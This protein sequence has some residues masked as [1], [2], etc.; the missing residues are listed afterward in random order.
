[1]ESLEQRVVLA[2]LAW[3]PLDEVSGT[4]A[5]DSSGNGHHGTVT[6][7]AWA[8]GQLDGAI[9]FNA[10]GNISVPS[11]ALA[12]VDQE[13][14]I[15]LWT[16]GGDTQPVSDSILYGVN[17][18][19]DRVFNVHLPFTNGRVY[20]D[21]GQD[22][23][24]DRINKVADPLVHRDSWHHWAFTKNVATGRMN[25]YL[26]G[27]LWHSG[28]G[29]TKSM[30][31]V[32]SF[33]LGAQTNGSESYDGLLDDVRI[34][35][36]EL[37]SAEVLGLFTSTTSPNTEEVLTTNRP[38]AVNDGGTVIITKAN[39]EA[40]DAEQSPS[41][42]TYTVTGIPANGTLHRSGTALVQYDTFT[43]DDLDN[44]R[45]TYGHNSGQSTTDSFTF[46]VNDG[47]GTATS[48]T[49]SLAVATVA[50]SLAELRALGTSV[51]NRLV[52]LSVTGGDPHPVT[53]VVTPGEYWI[54]GD[55]YADPTNSAPVF[56]ELSGTG[57][58]YDLAGTTI[59]LDTRK[60]DGFGRALGHDSGVDVVRV[61]GSG[62]VVKNLTV[63]GE[64]I[65]LDTDPNAQRYADWATQYI[66]L[67]GDDNTIDGVTVVTRGSR[68]D[69]YGL[70]DA[71]GKGSSGGVQPFI[72]HRKAS[73]FRVGEATNAVINNMHLDVNTFGHGFFVQ[74]STN[75]TL[76]N[77]TITGELFSSQG[78]LDRPEYQEY[79]HTFWGRP[80]PEDILISGNEGGVRM[81]TGASGLTVDNV[82]VTNMRTGFAVTLGSGTIT[83]NNVEAYGTENAFN[84][85]SNTTIT[86]AKGN[87]VNGPLIV[88]DKDNSA[89]S[90]IDV[91]LVGAAPINHGSAIAY[92]SGN[93]VD[94]TIT[95]DL[96]ASYFGD[97]HVFRASQFYADNWREDPSVVDLDL[98]GYDH[99]NS[100]ITNNTNMTLVLG[101]QATGN[102]GSSVGPVIT[103]GRENYY[104]GISLVP[105]GT[106]TIVQHV[107]GLGNNGTAADGS[108][109]TNASIVADGG[110]L[111][112]QSE[113][114][115][116]DEKL[117]ITGDGVD[118]NGALYTVGA[119]GSGTRFGSSNSGDESTIF[120]DGD[121]SI[122]VGVAG[123]QL[124]VGRIQGAGDLTKLGAGE[125]VMS[126]SS[127]YDGNLVVAEGHL[128][129]RSGIV[130]NDLA[131][132]AGA[133]IS[134]IS[135]SAFNTQ[136]D[137][138]LDGVLDLNARASTFISNLSGTIGA[139]HGSGSITSSNS[140]AGS[141]G[142]LTFSSDTDGF[143]AGTIDGE[144]SLVKSGAGTQALAG[145]MTHTRT[146]TIDGGVLQ[147]DG[148]HTGGLDYTV[149][150]NGTLGGN[151]SIGSSVTVNAAGHLAPGASAGSLSV[152]AVTLSSDAF[153]DVELAGATAG[154][155]Y[156]QLIANSAT[157]GGT[158]TV[159]LLPSGETIYL[160][161]ATET[162][163]VLVSATSLSG[164]FENVA[165]GQ[166]LETIGGEGTFL[167]TY[168]GTSNTVLLSDFDRLP[169]DFG[170]APSSYGT[171]ATHSGA[172][173][174]GTG[175]R[176]GALRDLEL[177]GQPSALATGDGD[178]EDGV[179]FGSIGIGNPMA[180]VNIDLQNASHAKV[181]AWIDF[182]GDG[183]WQ[184]DEKILDDRAVIAGLQT[185]NYSLP[186]TAPM[187]Q[188]IA[189]VR[190]SFAGGLQPTGAAA[191][192]EVED[193]VVTIG[194]AISP[195]VESVVVN[196]G[197]SQRSRVTEV[198]VRFST[199]VV[200]SVAAFSVRNR[201]TNQEVNLALNSE[202]ENGKTVATLTFLSG[203]GVVDAAN[204]RHSLD[205]GNYELLITGSMISAGGTAMSGDYTYGDQATDLFFQ[206]FG[207]SDGDRDVDG[208][209][210]GR[211]GLAFLAAFSD[212]KFNDSFDYD[213]DN[214]VDGQDYGRFGRSFL[215]QLSFGQ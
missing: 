186:A 74:L 77:S 65:A 165:S 30:A 174:G 131:V 31:G 181:D 135:N 38:L 67:S 204:G 80:I 25:I 12:T 63:I 54:N 184:A 10:D 120:L 172:R 202:I 198:S 50:N 21:A 150:A 213:Q 145:T 171:L 88:V 130:R 138:N 116:T 82:V 79:G 47:F 75:T 151:G 134:A 110:T 45:V 15:A 158:L 185:L 107:A 104:D 8:S 51:N 205:T 170:D 14:T 177:D 9:E 72:G 192:G 81:Y 43:Q 149:N 78:V 201:E 6:G 90:S 3:Y 99:V 4:V 44:N 157:L 46:V 203:P 180:G 179:L 191:D 95:S 60:L 112:L 206:L 26:D 183:I 173:H 48:G 2:T 62:N 163:T 208:Q 70:G 127:N 142:A 59:K 128:T 197:Q 195:E 23:G 132:A 36:H 108:L 109:E 168:S 214:D 115:I 200:A 119:V 5:T 136:G 42:L 71:F 102:T 66:E 199:E 144:V 64:D 176:L 11:A 24:Y 148:T 147:V 13:I 211:F 212:P 105:T 1:M 103:N 97:A 87:V 215:K 49:F 53:G 33:T 96:P 19:G 124:L 167:V 69:T 123:N 193:Y 76:T 187:G 7:G 155:E 111:E 39:L 133:S 169:Y 92:V 27:A 85:K 55:H 164:A 20:W 58:T 156:D 209:D 161:S 37:T 56:M 106:R 154:S 118:G 41:E 194:Q 89:N 129:G 166:R 175:P 61:S 83:L 139:L 122:G 178:D 94:V 68:T 143:F 196:Q 152:N 84:F 57:N 93:N 98:A 100:V 162:F 52:V 16:Y 113:I 28:T 140:T 22:A 153:F 121:A 18:V 141:G 207:D 35:D 146:T 137:V 40:T 17:A 29:K 91:E 188:A 117:T 182:D 32:T 159:S 114:R 189:R 73:A 126:K 101:E 125:L 34:Y 210:Y 86:N 190:L 160:P